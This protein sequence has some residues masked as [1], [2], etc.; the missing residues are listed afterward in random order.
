MPAAVEAFAERGVDD[1]RLR[2]VSDRDREQRVRVMHA[3]VARR[4]RAWQAATV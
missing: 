4:V 3:A 1:V 2:D